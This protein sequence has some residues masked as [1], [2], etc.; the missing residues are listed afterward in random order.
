[1]V[2]ITMDRGIW[3]SSGE[4]ETLLHEW[5]PNPGCNALKL[6]YPD[7]LVAPYCP[8]CKTSLLGPALTEGHGKRI[9]YHLEA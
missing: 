8:E 7:F 6:H 9:A 3:M 2:K 5:C 4:F 1:M